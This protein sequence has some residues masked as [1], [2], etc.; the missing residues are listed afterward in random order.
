MEYNTL[1]PRINKIGI[2]IFTLIWHLFSEKGNR[3]SEASRR[4][5]Q[6]G[7]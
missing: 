7:K 6:G 1:S 2:N 4:H 5:C 3:K